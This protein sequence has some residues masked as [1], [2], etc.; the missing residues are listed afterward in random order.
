MI[1]QKYIFG[2]MPHDVKAAN[3]EIKNML[4]KFESD[5]YKQA[6]LSNI[7]S[8]IDDDYQK[9]KYNLFKLCDLLDVFMYSK[10]EL[11]LGNT[12][13]EMSSIL[14]QS[15]EDCTKIVKA[16]KFYKVLPDNFNFIK[17]LDEIYEVKVVTPKTQAYN[18]I[19]DEMSLENK[20]E[21]K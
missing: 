10:E 5:F 18:Y 9:I 15:V 2:D 7:S 17:F 13:L 3:P 6:G 12:T 21:D 4:E 11:Y 19:P 16:L 20:M 14:A 8:I 1:L